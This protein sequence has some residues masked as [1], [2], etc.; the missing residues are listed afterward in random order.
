MPKS[1]KLI[2]RSRR[3]ERQKIQH[4]R[5]VGGL[6]LLLCSYADTSLGSFCPEGGDNMIFRNVGGLSI[7]YTDL[8]P[9]WQ[10]SSKD[11]FLTL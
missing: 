7:D 2:G 6:L 5:S 8:Y 3:V 10:Y 1:R 9:R 4:A 11:P